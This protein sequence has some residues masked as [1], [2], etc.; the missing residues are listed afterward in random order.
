MGGIAFR[1]PVLAALFLIATLATLAMPGSAN[2][3]GEFL[4]LLGRLQDAD[5]VRVHRLDRRRARVGLRAA[6]V[7]PHDAQPHGP[8]GRR[9]S[10]CRVRDA[11]V[12]V[13]LVLAI[14]AFALYPQ[15]ALD[16][17]R[18]GRSSA[19]WR[20]CCRPGGGAA[21]RDGG[22][23]RDRARPG[24]GAR[25]DRLGGAVARRRADRGRVPRAAARARAR[26]ASCARASCRCS[27]DRDAR[28]HRRPVRL[29]VGRERVDHRGRAR[30]G[31]PH[32]RR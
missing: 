6:L 18:A 15:A 14:V 23:R 10:S 29:A 3:V 1:A 24:Q 12:L 27:R 32:A 28:R 17:R 16:A 19:R 21:G 25:T 13:P 4:I 9:R 5:G 20:R 31:R 11:L 26:A 30:D 7:H 2:F 8:G 22:A